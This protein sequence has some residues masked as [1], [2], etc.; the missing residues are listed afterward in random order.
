MSATAL[1]RHLAL[2][3]FPTLQIRNEIAVLERVSRGHSNIV[4][5]HDYFEVSNH[6][7]GGVQI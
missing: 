4:T 6:F 3:L 1:Y 5:L 2:I 7:A